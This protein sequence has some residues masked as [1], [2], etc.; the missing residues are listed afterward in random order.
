VKGVVKLG[1]GQ[2][3]RLGLGGWYEPHPFASLQR[4]PR[5]GSFTEHG[6]DLGEGDRRVRRGLDTKRPEMQPYAFRVGE[7]GNGR[8]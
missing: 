5:R 8:A 6:R 3:L 1:Q 2:G 7:C 4:T